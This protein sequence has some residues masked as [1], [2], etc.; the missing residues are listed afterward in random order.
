M[1][2]DWVS[3]HVHF[4]HLQRALTRNDLMQVVRG[5]FGPDDLLSG[6]CTGSDLAIPVIVAGDKIRKRQLTIYDFFVKKQKRQR[7]L[8]ISNFFAKKAQP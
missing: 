2:M 4:H 3:R 7:Q 8:K 1:K 6:T 5:L